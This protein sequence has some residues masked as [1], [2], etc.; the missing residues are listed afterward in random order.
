MATATDTEAMI[1]LAG[2]RGYTLLCAQLEP[3]TL[4]RKKADRYARAAK[5]AGRARPLD[6]ITVARYVHL[7]DSRSEAMDDLRP[8]ITYELGFQMK[9]GL[10]R[11]LTSSYGL[12]FKDDEVSFDRLAEAGVYF[13]AIR[14]RSPA[15]CGSSTTPPADSGRC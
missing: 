8:A 11:I 9:R 14:I 5:T 2:Q 13:L 1:E 4:I 6:A 10:T 12:Q 15:S 3:A 7:A